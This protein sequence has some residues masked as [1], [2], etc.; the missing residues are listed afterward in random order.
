[1]EF[2]PRPRQRSGL[3]HHDIGV[4]L[5]VLKSTADGDNNEAGQQQYSEH[6]E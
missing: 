5:F 1:V 6:F 2:N 4:F 3:I